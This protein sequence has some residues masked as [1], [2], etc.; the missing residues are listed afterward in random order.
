V[1]GIRP[2]RVCHVKIMAR[3]EIR[4]HTVS[5]VPSAT[6]TAAILSTIDAS[7]KFELAETKNVP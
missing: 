2:P 6:T 5:Y 4:I 1:T 7:Q 3:T